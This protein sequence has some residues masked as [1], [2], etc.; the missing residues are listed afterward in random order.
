M[1]V[2]KHQG[3]RSKLAPL[4]SEFG[5]V[6]SVPADA[7]WQLRDD[8]QVQG[9]HGKVLELRSSTG[10]SGAQ[11]LVAKIGLWREPEGFVKEA[12]RVFSSI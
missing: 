8:V 11:V 6:T 10:G 9:S 7:S 3:K 12:A 5:S 1:Q 2:R 4:V